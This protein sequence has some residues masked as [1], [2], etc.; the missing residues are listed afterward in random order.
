MKSRE[1]EDGTDYSDDYWRYAQEHGQ[2]YQND[3]DIEEDAPINDESDNS[4]KTFYQS[5]IFP[6]HMLTSLKVHFL[7]NV[8]H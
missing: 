7:P 5:H 1:D 8:S 2:N 4:R 3:E 6:M